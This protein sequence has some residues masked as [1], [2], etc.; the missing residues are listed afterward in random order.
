MEN[1]GDSVLLNVQKAHYCNLK[2]K[3]LQCRKRSGMAGME[4]SSIER[5][6]NSW[7]FRRAHRRACL[8]VCRPGQ[9]R[10]PGP[11][12]TTTAM[13]KTGHQHLQ[14]ASNIDILHCK[15]NCGHFL[16][17]VRTRGNLPLA[18]SRIN[19]SDAPKPGNLQISSH[20]RIT[21]WLGLTIYHFGFIHSECARHSSACG[22]ERKQTD[23]LP[24]PTVYVLMKKA[25]KK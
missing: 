10:G 11:Q 9:P 1:G 13:V 12:P 14:E 16:H 2:N 6:Q 15:R 24:V 17:P 18:V 25:G 23:E 3:E 22:D 5:G 7:K 4:G 19:A 8:L 21:R 20:T